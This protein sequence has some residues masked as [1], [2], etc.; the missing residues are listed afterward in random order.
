MKTLI[1]ILVIAVTISS[2]SKLGD[3]VE[4][5]YEIALISQ[6][7]GAANISSYR[8]ITRN[9]DTIEMPE[10]KF[11]GQFSDTL[12]CYSGEIVVFTVQYDGKT[13]GVNGHMIIQ[14]KG[15]VERFADISTTSCGWKK[16]QIKYIVLQ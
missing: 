14:K 16:F 7:E 6:V 5:P 4:Q 10:I 13:K 15:K 11:D 2:C 3:V 12:V 1:I 9:G 8:H